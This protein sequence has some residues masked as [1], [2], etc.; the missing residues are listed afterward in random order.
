MDPNAPLTLLQTQLEIQ[1]AKLGLHNFCDS[2]SER[3]HTS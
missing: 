3:T 2:P 1:D